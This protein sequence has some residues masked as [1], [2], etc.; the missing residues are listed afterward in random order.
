MRS[1]NLLSS[2]T[3]HLQVLDTQG[4]KALTETFEG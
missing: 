3:I 4:S 1:E 2:P